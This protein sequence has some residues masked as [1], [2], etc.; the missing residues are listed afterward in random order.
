MPSKD[1]VNRWLKMVE[2]FFD[3]P[4]ETTPKNE[5][6]KGEEQKLD[7]RPL[8]KAKTIV[9]HKRIGVHCVAGLGRAPLLVALAIVNKGCP[10]AQAI[11][12]IR[13]LR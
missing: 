7:R 2:D 8:R 9:D 1:I 3:G 11:E 6:H 4:E 5:E 10:P 12:L 13:K